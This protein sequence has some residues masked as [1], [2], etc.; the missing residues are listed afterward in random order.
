M[1]D[2]YY[3]H[4]TAWPMLFMAGFWLVVVGLV[5]FAV[6]RLLPGRAAPPAPPA[7]PHAPWPPQPAAETPEEIL[8]R[9]FARGEID[10]ATYRAQREVLASTRGAPRP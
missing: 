7:R 5:V 1:M 10:E 4:G 9:R 3:G 2:W 8:D 6:V